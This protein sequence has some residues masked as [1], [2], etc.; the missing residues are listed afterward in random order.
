M[1]SSKCQILAQN[2]TF[3]MLKSL[4]NDNL[5]MLL[6]T[7]GDQIRFSNAL[8]KK[9][10]KTLDVN[11]TSEKFKKPRELFVCDTVSQSCRGSSVFM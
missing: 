6:P 10:L 7:I 5:K 1:S 4:G 2:I 9:G 3:S 11:K 8:K